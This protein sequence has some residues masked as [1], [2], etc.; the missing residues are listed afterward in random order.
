M[1]STSEAKNV[2]Q[3]C[4]CATYFSG[5]L[6]KRWWW[7]WIAMMIMVLSPRVEGETLQTTPICSRGQNLKWE[8]DQSTISTK[9]SLKKTRWWDI[10]GQLCEFVPVS[11]CFGRDLVCIFYAFIS[12]YLYH[13]PWASRGQGASF[14]IYNRPLSQEEALIA[15]LPL[16]VK[17]QFA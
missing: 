13:A 8:P 4:N 6:I 12:D 10:W 15:D 17:C 5:L 14:Q 3:S 16:L 9:W 11:G 7:R 2:L 1:T